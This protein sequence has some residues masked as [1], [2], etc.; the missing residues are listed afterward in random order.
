[1]REGFGG[2]VEVD[3]EAGAPV[4][5]EV[6]YEGAAECGLGVRELASLCCVHGDV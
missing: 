4:V 6:R 3:V 1:M 5:L 2:R